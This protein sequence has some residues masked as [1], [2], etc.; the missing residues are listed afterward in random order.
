MHRPRRLRRI[1]TRSSR[2]RRP[3][4]ALATTP[5]P[6]TRLAQCLRRRHRGRGAR[7]ATRR[8]TRLGTSAR[9]TMPEGGARRA[10]PPSGSTSSPRRAGQPPLPRRQ[11]IHSDDTGVS[12]LRSGRAACVEWCV[13]CRL[14]AQFV[15]SQ[16]HLS[17][18]QR[19]A[20][21]VESFSFVLLRVWLDTRRVCLL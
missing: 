19:G 8:A 6:S 9:S 10:T 16:E 5:P 11:A 4:L 2:V 18:R 3:G 17:D 21:L 7:R 1:T 20:S 12:R 14:R 13:V 15:L